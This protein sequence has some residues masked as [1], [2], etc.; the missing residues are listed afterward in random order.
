MIV[1]L[2]LHIGGAPPLLAPLASNPRSRLAVQFWHPHKS[3]GACLARG[4]AGEV[5]LSLPR[6]RRGGR[7]VAFAVIVTIWEILSLCGSEVGTFCHRW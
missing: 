7:T 3:T 5:R 6:P 1:C 2:V 4:G